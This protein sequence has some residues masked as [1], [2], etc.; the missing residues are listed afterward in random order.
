M[1]YL[2]VT[3]EYCIGWCTTIYY[4]DKL[5]LM[6]KWK[7]ALHLQAVFDPKQFIQI[8]DCPI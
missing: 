8:K 1:T 6:E 3:I 4:C 2:N 5:S 7:S